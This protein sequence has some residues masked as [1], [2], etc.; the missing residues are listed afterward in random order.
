[1]SRDVHRDTDAWWC[2]VPSFRIWITCGSLALACALGLHVLIQREFV[3]PVCQPC[4]RSQGLVY[5]GMVFGAGNKDVPAQ[6]RC[7]FRSL[8]EVDS[9]VPLQ[10]CGPFLLD[11]WVT[12]ALDLSFMVP[13]LTI[14]IV[15]THAA[16]SRRSI[17]SA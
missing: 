15:W 12:F 5:R 4:A 17:R 3:D 11:L 1:M 9:E 16:W 8:D 14:A 10:R 2:A 7:G 13:V 6:T